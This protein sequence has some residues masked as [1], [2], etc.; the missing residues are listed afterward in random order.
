MPHFSFCLEMGAACAC[1]PFLETWP[2]APCRGK[3]PDPAK[4]REHVLLAVLAERR[5]EQGKSAELAIVSVAHL[6]DEERSLVLGV[7]LEWI[8]MA[9]EPES[10]HYSSDPLL[11]WPGTSPSERTADSRGA[12]AALVLVEDLLDLRRQHGIVDGSSAGLAD[13]LSILPIRGSSLYSRRSTVAGS[14]K[15]RFG[16]ASS[17]AAPCATHRSTV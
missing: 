17:R 10:A 11:V 4:S 3:K 16:L 8:R 14:I 1:R 5:L 12:V 7:L 2:A 13:L 6:D 9:A 15:S